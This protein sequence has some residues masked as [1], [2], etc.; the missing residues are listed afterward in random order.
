MGN[1]NL[2][3]GRNAAMQTVTKTEIPQPAV[4]PKKRRWFPAVIGVLAAAV[5]AAIVLTPG[6][7]ASTPIEI[8]REYMEAR[9]AFDAERA[10]SLLSADASVLDAPRMSR[11]ELK[12]GFEALRV[13]DAQWEPFECTSKAGTTLVTCAYSLE[14]NLSRIVGHP[15][16]AGSIL[17]LVEEG[18]IQSLVHNFNYDD[19]GTNVLGKFLTWLG[20]EHPGAIEE[21]Y[22]ERDGVLSPNLDL[23]ALS[24]L[25]GFIEE[26]DRAVNG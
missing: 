22:V 26:Y 13:Y 8:G 1:R 20:T 4:Q 3:E 2:N 16:V 10:S 9:N 23:K 5:L 17:L 12:Q 14:T 7:S 24:Q 6:D 11:T 18:Q 21:V 25:H 15:P 19:Y